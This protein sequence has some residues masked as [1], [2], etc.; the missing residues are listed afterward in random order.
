[1][2]KVQQTD[3]QEQEPNRQNELISAMLKPGFYPNRPAEVTH[4]ETHIS[5]L[6]FAGD[7]V[8]KIKKAVRFSF[9]DYSTLGKRRYYI[10]EELSLNRRLA[11]TVYLGVVPIGCDVSGWRLGASENPLEFALLMRR[12][13]DSRMLP[14]LLESAQITPEMMRS[15][16]QVLAGFHANAQ[17]LHPSGAATHFDTVAKQ[18]RDNLED[19][20]QLI[21]NAI[22][23]ES[24]AAIKAFGDNFLDQNRGFISRRA[25]DGWVRDGHGDLHCEH[26]CFA[27]EGIQIFDCIEFDPQLRL[28]D[29]A[30]EIGFLLMDLE[31]RGGAPLGEALL[32]RYSDLI[33]D[34]NL[35]ILLPFYKCYRALIR[36]KV[37]ALR[38]GASAATVR[39]FTIAGRQTWTPYKPFVVIVCGLT[40][41]GKSTLARE[42]SERIGIDVINSDVVRKELTGK[43]GRGAPFNQ[44]IYSS[45]ITEK[46]YGEMFDETDRRLSHG[47]S[48]MLDAT[49]AQRRYREKLVAIAGRHHAPVYFLHCV[50]S[51][52]LT[53]TRLRERAKNE[54]EVS[55][56]RWEIYLEQKSMEEPLDDCSSEVCLELSAD[57]SIEDLRRLSERF[58]RGRLSSSVGN[59]V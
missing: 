14:V 15:L 17:Q 9:L 32:I 31:A 48:A 42:L 6:F 18:W 21:G 49:F 23:L 51:D 13:P 37:E 27:P 3:A 41:S 28:C 55:D 22:D 45:E 43:S 10:D 26:V 36:G 7:L 33:N 30:S 56:G 12:L 59:F 29:L 20:E 58:L 50:A 24:F 40:G 25:F 44:G 38:A 47:Q 1:M 8:Y 5:H 16:A 57:R 52:G 54:N 53:Q 35:P 4:K 39:Y 11:P 2:D 46:T 34:S 19:V